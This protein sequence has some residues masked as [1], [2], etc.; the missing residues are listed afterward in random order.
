MDKWKQ[1]NWVWLSNMRVAPKWLKAPANGKKSTKSCGPIP[2][3]LTLAMPN[4]VAS[5]TRLHHPMSICQKA[6]HD[7]RGALLR[8]ALTKKARSAVVLLKFKLVNVIVYP[9]FLLSCSLTRQD[10][11]CD[12]SSF[13]NF[14]VIC[15]WP[16]SCV[17]PFSLEAC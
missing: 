10:Y 7:P 5:P 12:A 14:V 15:C 13:L 8:G 11:S 3:G 17:R 2:S 4:S 16:P 6:D 1:G 9:P